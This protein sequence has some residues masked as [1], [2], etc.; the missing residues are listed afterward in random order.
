MPP[1]R[2]NAPFCNPSARDTKI[3]NIST[4]WAISDANAKEAAT[5][6]ITSISMMVGSKGHD[7]LALR[8]R[9]IST[10]NEIPIKKVMIAERCSSAARQSWVA[11][12]IAASTKLPVRCPVNVFA[13]TKLAASPY[14]PTKASPKETHV[15]V[16]RLVDSTI[17][18]LW[19]L[20]SL[21]KSEGREDA[22]GD[23]HLKSK[24]CQLTLAL[25]A[26]GGGL[27]RQLSTVPTPACILAC[28]HVHE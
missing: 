12:A 11:T 26:S 8:G 4:P 10:L 6:R 14:P 7:G 27:F 16:W 23:P 9:T 1:T 5:I 24:I 21:R 15:S 19:R 28:R 18:L 3:T 20:R 22:P 13:R 25:L 2:R 17:L